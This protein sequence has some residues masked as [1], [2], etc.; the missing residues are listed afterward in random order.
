MSGVHTASAAMEQWNHV[1]DAETTDHHRDKPLRKF[2]T[3]R[4]VLPAHHQSGALGP[5]SDQARL[6]WV[7]GVF[8]PSVQ[9]VLG[10]L[11]FLRLPWIIGS[12]GVR[13]AIIMVHFCAALVSDKLCDSL[14][15]N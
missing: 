1:L 4:G 12:M 7:R 10:T 14:S 13:R 6:G 5:Q 11:F 3:L 9:N 2:G 15:I 8:V